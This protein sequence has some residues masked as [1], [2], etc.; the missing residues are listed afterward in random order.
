MDTERDRKENRK[1]MEGSFKLQGIKKHAK[2]A[3]RTKRLIGRTVG[4]RERGR[5]E[6]ERK[7]M[8]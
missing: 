4:K 1:K 7:R 3:L 5:E 6:G 2:G 8:I